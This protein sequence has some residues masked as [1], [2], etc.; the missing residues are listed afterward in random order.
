VDGIERT[1]SESEI[2]FSINLSK[3]LSRNTRIFHFGV[4]FEGESVCAR[5]GEIFIFPLPC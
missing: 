1:A 2:S 5:G 3:P 4:Y